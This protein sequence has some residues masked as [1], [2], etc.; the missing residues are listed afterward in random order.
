M[1][2]WRG[3]TAECKKRIGEPSA[4][5]GGVGYGSEPTWRQ[6]SLVAWTREGGRRGS[7]TEPILKVGL[8]IE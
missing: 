6:M 3:R 7:R 4:R 2:L 5:W 1:L 8:S